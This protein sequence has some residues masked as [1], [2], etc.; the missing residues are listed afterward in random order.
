MAW[1]AVGS[2]ATLGA[3]LWVSW[4]MGLAEQGEFGLAKSWFD[5]AAVIAALGLPQ[6]LLHLQY[7]CGVGGG[8]GGGRGGRVIFCVFL[9]NFE[10]L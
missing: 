2:A 8:G 10:S 1:Q 3:A 5:A 7:R 6:G 4:R 9:R